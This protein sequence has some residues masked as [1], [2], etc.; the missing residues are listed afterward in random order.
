ML[1]KDILD[2]KP[3][4]LIKGLT[5]A[6]KYRYSISLDGWNFNDQNLTED[7]FVLHV[8]NDGLF[9][10]EADL[11][12]TTRE[13]LSFT[14]LRSNTLAFGRKEAFL[15]FGGNPD[16]S[17]IETMLRRMWQPDISLIEFKPIP[18]AGI[19]GLSLGVTVAMFDH[20]INNIYSKEANELICYHKVLI[21]ETVKWIR[22]SSG[23]RPYYDRGD[24]D[25]L[26]SSPMW[27]SL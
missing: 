26:L 10:G 1:L 19:V 18:T 12:E 13:I 14:H 9:V 16:I 11:I 17:L 3:G 21:E 5:F 15:F 27:I 4:T 25:N 6:K 23:I 20:S 24:P 2:I 8:F 7:Y 22:L